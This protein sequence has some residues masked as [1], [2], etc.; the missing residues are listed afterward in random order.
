[1]LCFGLYFFIVIVFCV[2][3]AI[4][5]IR[6]TP[7]NVSTTWSLATN[8]CQFKHFCN[9]TG[10]ALDTNNKIIFLKQNRAEKSYPF[11]DIREFEYNISTGGNVVAGNNLHAA[12]YNVGVHSRNKAESGLFITVRDID[13][14]QWQISFP[15]DKRMKTE[16]L[17][18]MEIFRQHVNNE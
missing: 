8:D 7:N 17:K 11:S 18:W 15:H 5:D 10:I 14:P 6:R 12:M 9:S 13:H 3:F 4:W 2:C 1:M 16:L